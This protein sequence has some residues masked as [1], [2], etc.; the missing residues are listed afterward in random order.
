MKKI[1]K[2]V[3]YVYILRCA[4]DTLYTGWSNNLEKRI[5]DHGLGRGA[6]YTKGRG[7][8]TLVYFESFPTKQEA[9]SREAVIKR[10]TKS[11]KLQL[12]KR[13]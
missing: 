2:G 8:L 10:M 7:P 5:S 4:D 1:E 13:D 6:K 9:M 11:K 3:N 12:I